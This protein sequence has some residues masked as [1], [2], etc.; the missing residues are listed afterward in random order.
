MSPCLQRVSWDV[1][2]VAICLFLNFFL[3]EV[4]LAILALGNLVHATKKEVRV[5]HVMSSHFL[6]ESELSS[7]PAQFQHQHMKAGGALQA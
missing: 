6:S 7:M 2:R 5:L 3:K 1:Q 4:H